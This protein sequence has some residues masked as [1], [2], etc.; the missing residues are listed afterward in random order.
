MMIASG[1]PRL[2]GILSHTHTYIHTHNV[3]GL[4]FESWPILFSNS[5]A[6][7]RSLT[8]MDLSHG[9]HHFFYLTRMKT[10]L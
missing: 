10:R 5:A 1:I 2:T 7:P 4:N 8:S 3:A 9:R 6:I